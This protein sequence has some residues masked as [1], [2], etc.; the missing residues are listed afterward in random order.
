[1]L[2]ELSDD[3]VVEQRRKKLH[4]PGSLPHVVMADITSRDRDGELIAIPT[5][6][7]EDAHGVPPKIHIHAVRKARPGEIAGVGDRVLLRAEKSDTDGDA[8]SYAGRVIKIID[9][10]KQRTLGIFRALSGGDGRLAPI[11]KKQLGREFTIPAGATGDAQDGDLVAVETAPPSSAC[12]VN[13]PTTVSSSNGARSCIVPAAC[14][15]S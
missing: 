5:E 15:M 12:C 7:D 10:A 13:S 14:P 4:R 11:D 3:G 9:R 8:V 1:M 2:R 6:W